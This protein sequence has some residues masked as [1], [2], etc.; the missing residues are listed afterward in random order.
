MAAPLMPKAT[1]VWMVENTALTFQQIGDF[2]GLHALE[3]QG[4]ADG[5]VAQGIKGLDPVGNGQLTA[6]EL[7]RCAQDPTARLSMRRADIPLPQ[8]RSKGPRYTPLSKRQDKPDAISYLVRHFPELTDAQISRL[9]GTTKPTITAVRERSHWNSANI[10]PRDPVILGLC[11]QFDL[12]E[13]TARAHAAGRAPAEVAPEA[14]AA[15]AGARSNVPSWLA[16]VTLSR[17]G[18]E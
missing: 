4:I 18:E 9:L 15:D 7:E 11:R 12:D 2:C 17:T 3:V 10:R 1:A 6:E 13:A 8:K 14:A 16:G 5:E